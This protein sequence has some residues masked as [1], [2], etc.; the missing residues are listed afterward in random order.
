MDLTILILS[1]LVS[2]A[3]LIL[4]VAAIFASIGYYKQGGNKRT[5]D[6]QTADLNTISLLEKSVGLLQ[7]E[8]KDLAVRVDTLTKDNLEKSRQLQDWMLVFQGRDPKMQEFIK[9]L[10]EYTET[11]KPAID[12]IIKDVYPVIRNME[13]WLNKQQF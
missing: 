5:L 1:F 3:M 11:G 4:A 13:K 12:I 7:K 10:T 6:E 2:V 8:V 9:V